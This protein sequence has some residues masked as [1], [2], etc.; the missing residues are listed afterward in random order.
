MKARGNSKAVKTYS[1]NTLAICH[2]VLEYWPSA[3][4]VIM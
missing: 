4:S 2:S 1:K 3:P